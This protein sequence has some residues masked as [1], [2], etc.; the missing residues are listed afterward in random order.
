MHE[1]SDLKKYFWKDVPWGHLCRQRCTE[2]ATGPC[3]LW[4]SSQENALHCP[5]CP[6]LYRICPCSPEISTNSDPNSLSYRRRGF[7][8]G[9]GTYEE[10]DSGVIWGGGYM[11]LAGDW[12]RVFAGTAGC[13]G[14]PVKL[15]VFWM[16]HVATW[17]NPW[18]LAQP[19]T[20]LQYM[21]PSEQ[22]ALYGSAQHAISDY[23]Q[24]IQI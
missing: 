1:Y 4:H 23:I 21:Y 20:P 8:L 10:E 2:Q 12:Y 14:Q 22:E 5:S 3:R 17:S 9:T 19:G 13:A 11:C 7:W 15:E 16:Q 18:S 6:Y 24:C